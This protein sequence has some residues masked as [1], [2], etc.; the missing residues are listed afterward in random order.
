LSVSKNI[1]SQKHEEYILLALL[2]GQ[3]QLFTKEDLNTL[4]VGDHSRLARAQWLSLSG[5]F[6]QA[7]KIFASIQ[8]IYPAILWQYR[9]LHLSRW[10]EAL[11]A[12]PSA[13]TAAKVA[14][15][16]RSASNLDSLLGQHF[17]AL[18]R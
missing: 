3:H 9:Q 5:D 1:L 8:R 2:S 4:P 11:E 6:E 17:P 16:N 12:A 7:E 15:I 14:Y 13:S 18:V 10:V